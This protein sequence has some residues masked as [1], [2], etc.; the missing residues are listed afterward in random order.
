LRSVAISTASSSGGGGRTAAGPLRGV[1]YGERE[2]HWL[3]NV[4]EP[5]GTYLVSVPRD[6]GG[7]LR[8]AFRS[9]SSRMQ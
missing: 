6:V 8:A 5:I 2:L 4:S 9:A 3:R 1:D 7:R